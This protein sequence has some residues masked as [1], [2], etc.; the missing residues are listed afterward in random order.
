MHGYEMMKAL[1]ERAG[2]FYTPSAGAIYPTLQLLEDR[3]WVTSQTVD[4]KKVY[5]ITDAGRQALTEQ[6]AQQAPSGPWGHRHGPWGHGGPRGPFGARHNPALAALR[7]EGMEVARL[8]RDAV[9]ASQGDPAKLTELQGIVH[10]A[11]EALQRFV[12]Q[13]QQSQSQTPPS[14]SGPIEQA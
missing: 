13:Q 9:I 8:M 11:R 2:G 1:E 3:G 14:A 6:G 7:T 12:N 10:Q 4:A 5:T